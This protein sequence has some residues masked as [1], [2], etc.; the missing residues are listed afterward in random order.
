VSVTTEY[1]DLLVEFVPRP[2]RT[3]KEYQSA[4]A[5]LDRLMVP[6]PGPAQSLLIEVLSMLIEKFES[7]EYPT[8][9]TSPA[10][11]LAHLLQSRGLKCASLAQQTGIPAAT[12]SNVLA[13]RRGISKASAIKLATVFGVSPVVFFDSAPASAAKRSRART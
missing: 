4:K 12:L 1:R 13:G 8:P 5:K 9:T 7:R 10:E 2:I 11:M 6:H 3:A